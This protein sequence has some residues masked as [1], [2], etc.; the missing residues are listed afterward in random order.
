MGNEA[1][2]ARVRA[3]LR[4]GRAGEALAQAQQLLRADAGDAEPNFLMAAA[5][6][7]CGDRGRAAHFAQRGAECAG[8][9]AAAAVRASMLLAGAGEPALAA[10]LLARAIERSPSDA[11]LRL[12]A[13]TRALLDRDGLSCERHCR[14][15]LAHW[16]GDARLA[17]TLAAA[18][19]DSGRAGEAIGVARLAL[20]SSPDDITL[21]SQACHAINYVSTDAEEVRAA[22]RAFGALMTRLRGPAREFPRAGGGRP[23]RIALV[24]TDLRRH[25]VSYFIEAFLRHHDRGAIEITVFHGAMIDDVSRRLFAFAARA[26]PCFGGSDADFAATIRAHRPDIVLELNGHTD[27]PTMAG[28]HHRAAPVQT[29]YLGYPAGTGLGSMDVRIVDSITDPPGSDD[30]EGERPVRLDPCFLCYTPPTDAPARPV[31]DPS[32]PATF[33][34]FN[35]CA[36]IGDGLLELWGRVLG[37]VPGSRLVLKS[38]AFADAGLRERTARRAAAA[39]IDTSR[40]S[41]LPPHASLADHLAAYGEVDV[42]LDTMPYNGTTTTCEALWMGTPVVTLAG[43][44]HAGRVGA[45]LLHAAGLPDLVAHDEAGYVAL[46]AGLG[47]DGPRR[48]ALHASLRERLTASALCDGP[49]HTRRLE[50]ALLGLHENQ[51]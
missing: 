36:K 45:S 37:A 10:A 11:D 9:G 12:A 1:R 16:P 29:T 23:V 49:G 32:R 3:L 27:P 4:E 20:K 34:S 7:A 35:A 30:P 42:A 24:S 13:A 38:T 22:H 19:V 14:E 40:L 15:G 39:G 41:V 26:V 47:R 28:L 6:L 2:H 33:G 17:S 25:S 51:T 5:C 21:A 46:A 31:R 48:A 8:W 43:R 50:G 44:L 18:L